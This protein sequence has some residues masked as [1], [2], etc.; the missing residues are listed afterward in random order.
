MQ[1]AHSH[2]ASDKV[3]V[4]TQIVSTSLLYYIRL[5]SEG[6]AQGTQQRNQY[7]VFVY[8]YL[9]LHDLLFLIQS[10]NRGSGKPRSKLNSNIYIFFFFLN[11]IIC[12]RKRAV[13]QLHGSIN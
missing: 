3:G 11:A 9:N 8:F 12:Q 2:T 10:L 6:Y 5:C 4:C 13:S 1:L 7:W